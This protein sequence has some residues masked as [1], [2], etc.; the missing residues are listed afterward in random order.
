MVTPKPRA[1]FLKPAF[2]SFF[3]SAGN[4]KSLPEISYIEEK[5]NT[6][7]DWK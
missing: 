3:C 4:E 6:S 1:I 7:T 2:S 5:E